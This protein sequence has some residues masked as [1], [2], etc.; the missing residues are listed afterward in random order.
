VCDACCKRPVWDFNCNFDYPFLKVDGIPLDVCS[1]HLSF[2]TFLLE[3]GQFAE[4]SVVLYE[5][6]AILALHS[7]RYNGA[8]AWIA[9]FRVL[10]N[11]HMPFGRSFGVSSQLQSA[12]L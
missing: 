2:C 7:G 11:D 3:S 10:T 1:S 4:C 5:A 6:H 8:V 12:K 9:I